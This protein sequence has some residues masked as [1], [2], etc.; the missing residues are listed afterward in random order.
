MGK[1]KRVEGEAALKARSEGKDG[2]YSPATVFV[3]NLLYSFQSSQLE[4]VFSE[5]G[6]VRR[7]FLV[8]QKGSSLHRGFGFVQFASTEDADKAVQLKDGLVIGGRRI[9]VKH[10][11]RRLPLGHRRSKANSHIEDNN[12]DVNHSTIAKSV[13]PSQNQKLETFGDA[14]RIKRKMVLNSCEDEKLAGSGKQR[15]ARTVIFGNLLNSDMADEVFHRAREIGNVRLIQYP[16]R[17]EDLELHGLAR[18]GCKVD[19]SAVEFTCVKSARAA[20]VA[21]HQQE[22]NGEHVWARQLGGEGSNTRKWRLIVRNLPFKVTADE[23]KRIFASTGFVWD[24][25]IPCGSE[26]GS[27]KGFAFV[28]FTCKLD[29]EKAIESTNGQSIRK[30][31]IAVDWAVSKKIFIASNLLSSKD[32]KSI[33][34]PEIGRDNGNQVDEAINVS[35]ESQDEKNEETSDDVECEDHPP[36]I[37]LKMEA[38]ITNKVLDKLI[39]T[40]AKGLSANSLLEPSENTYGTQNSQNSE[41]M[42]PFNPMVTSKNVNRRKLLSIESRERDSDLDRTLFLSNLPFDI[43]PEDV[44]QRFSVFGEVQ[45]FL[46]VLHKVTKRP[47]GTAFLKFCTTNAANVAVSAA[48]AAA[49]TGITMKGRHL[50][51]MKALDKDSA[52]K[53]QLE[54]K[55]AE[56]HDHRNLYL[57]NE[58]EILTGTPAA[59]GVSVSDMNKRARLATKKM[60]MLQSSNFHVSRTRLIIY[61]LPKTITEDELKVLCRDAVLSR[62]SK[63]NPVI[64]QAKLLKDLK[65][66]KDT[67]KKHPRRVAFV[68]FREHEHALVC[69]RVLNNNPETFGPGHR[70]IVEFALE[71]VR[72]LR[73]RDARLEMQK[74]KPATSKDYSMDLQQ[75]S[76][77]HSV[78]ANSPKKDMKQS[79]EVNHHKGY[80]KSS[81]VSESGERNG[82]LEHPEEGMEVDISM[83]NSGNRQQK[84]TPTRGKKTKFSVRRKSVKS[85]FEPSNLQEGSGNGQKLGAPHSRKKVKKG[86]EAGTHEPGGSKETPVLD[87]RKLKDTGPLQEREGRTWKKNKGKSGEEVV[88]RLDILIEQYRAKLSRHSSKVSEDSAVRNSGGLKRWFEL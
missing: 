2:E 78:D 64:H 51:V 49:S 47:R 73:L 42:I 27:S 87:K 62:A 55:K 25:Y 33:D 79:K 35:G 31:T 19:A 17:K 40:S 46:P 10:A 88:D 3:S 59:E 8:T 48:N 21:L 4:E 7:C 84:E 45:S 76:T 5:V 22:I 83:L 20:V 36:K 24:V 74:G 37:D 50:S 75:D 39:K 63:Q 11:M 69:L 1:R 66:G 12:N 80:N 29:A 26:E 9:R 30:R 70:P 34:E 86:V 14:K 23:I 81:K 56:V 85:I 44:K 67:A 13:G 32:E 72:K 53:K 65:K 71:D 28:S 58:G 6:P 60:M 15:V 68:E 16:L 43:D 57:A 18:D 54:K 82:E 38:D 52:H 61:N 41:H 77:V